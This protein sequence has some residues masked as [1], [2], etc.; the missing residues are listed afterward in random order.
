M[1]HSRENGLDV[2]GEVF[3]PGVMHPGGLRG[4]GPMLPVVLHVGQPCSRDIGQ[5]RWREMVCTRKPP[6]G[7][8]NHVFFLGG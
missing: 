1:E 8:R 4:V 2:V 3:V 5:D 6:R 7:V